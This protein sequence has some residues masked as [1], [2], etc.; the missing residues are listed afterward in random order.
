MV[1]PDDWADDDPPDNRAPLPPEDRLWRHPSELYGVPAAGMAAGVTTSE[2]R[3]VS[4]LPAIVAACCAAALLA[5]TGFHVL[6]QP[7]P[8]LTDS[9]VATTALLA[10]TGAAPPTT[11]AEPAG[12]TVGRVVTTSVMPTSVVA[13]SAAP[14]TP[15]V[16]SAVSATTLAGGGTPVATTVPPETPGTSP[17]TT[18]PGAVRLAV[19]NGDGEHSADALVIDTAGTV[20]T[21][22]AALDGA[23]SVTVDLGVAGRWPATVLGQDPETGTAV[24][25]V[26]DAVGATAAPLGDAAHL[27][28]GQALRTGSDAAVDA[29]LLGLGV[30]DRTS[31]GDR[32]H[33]LAVALDRPGREGE[34]LLG[35]DGRVVGLCTGGS[36]GR[37][38][39]IPIELVRSTA[40]SLRTSGRLV[41]PW[42]GIKG[43]DADQGGAVLSTVDE[44]SPAA[45]A[46]LQEG[47]RVVAVDDQPV[48]SMPAL[49]LAIRGHQPGDQLTLTIDRAG[50]VEVLTVVLA[51][52]PG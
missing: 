28:P 32:S 46:G 40:R 45:A 48:V 6:F 5:A 50:R 29:L 51:E 14:T 35:A 24:L 1:E 11:L 31:S 3:G 17:V 12:T 34:P 52:R 19:T 23:V 7:G 30:R 26:A 39:A 4:W 43:Q 8:A 10:P 41:V 16:T 20:V 44:G 13:T 47:D 2:P 18:V 33:L 36:D 25:T 37:T 49:V 21:T 9:A 22:S 42:A 27:T 15:S 38:L